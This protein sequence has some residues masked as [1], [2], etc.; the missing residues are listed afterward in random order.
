MYF[1]EINIPKEVSAEVIGSLV[2]VKGPKGELSRNF[3]LKTVKGSVKIEK[4]KS[5]VKQHS[6][7]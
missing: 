6:K 4:R 5:M 2:K 3:E 1:E 7:N